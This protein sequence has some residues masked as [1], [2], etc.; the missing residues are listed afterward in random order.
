MSKVIARLV[1]KQLIEDQKACRMTIAKD[2]L[3]HSNHNENQ[4]L[5]FI[6]FG[7]EMWAHYAE[8]ET[9]A[10][11]KQWKPANSPPPKK[12]NPCRAE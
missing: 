6:D 4:F 12:L 1:L 2:H 9:K 3:G 5:N 11:S 10:Q 8:P 7:D